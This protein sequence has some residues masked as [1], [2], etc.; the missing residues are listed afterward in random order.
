MREIKETGIEIEISVQGK[1]VKLTQ[2]VSNHD[3]EDQLVSLVNTALLLEQNLN[4][5]LGCAVRIVTAKKSSLT[6]SKTVTL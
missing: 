6:A 2:S 3:L 4:E 1:T 5:W